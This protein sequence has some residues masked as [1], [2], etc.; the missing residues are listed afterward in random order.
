MKAMVNESDE[1]IKS[2]R[3][4]ET[5]ELQEVENLLIADKKNFN[6]LINKQIADVRKRKLDNIELEL[7]LHRIKRIKKE[8][9]EWKNG[10]AFNKVFYE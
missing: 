3:V 2:Q 7:F 4:V 6:R 9:L 5:L 8:P 1:P 10:V